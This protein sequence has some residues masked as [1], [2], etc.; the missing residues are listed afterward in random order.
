MSLL[1]VRPK[2]CYVLEERVYEEITE[3]VD[4]KRRFK[5]GLPVNEVISSVTEHGVTNDTVKE[6]MVYWESY[7]DLDA[8]LYRMLPGSASAQE[9][10]P[11]LNGIAQ[12]TEKLHAGFFEE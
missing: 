5:S 8:V 10:H 6:E 1:G 12:L 2:E 9:Y 11:D 7:R 4:G 3:L